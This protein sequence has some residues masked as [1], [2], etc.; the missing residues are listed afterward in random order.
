MLLEYEMSCSPVVVVDVGLGFLM[1]GQ[2]NLGKD[3]AVKSAPGKSPPHAYAGL[4]IIQ[5]SEYIMYANTICNTE[6]M[7]WVSVSVFCILTEN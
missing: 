6:A 5:Y 2:F 1:N 3:L 4:Y 7:F